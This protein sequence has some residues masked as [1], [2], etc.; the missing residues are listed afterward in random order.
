MGH[1]AIE[2]EQVGTKKYFSAS[3]NPKE[4]YGIF[5]TVLSSTTQEEDKKIFEGYFL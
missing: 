4:E 2:A 1:L 3:Y 5:K